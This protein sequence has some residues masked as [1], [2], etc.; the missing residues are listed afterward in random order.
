MKLDPTQLAAARPKQSTWLIANAGSGKTKVLV[1]RLLRLLLSGARPGGI[2]CLTFTKTAA[3]EM[4]KRVQDI[5]GR[6][7]VLDDESLDAE[8]LALG[9]EPTERK[10]QQARQLFLSLAEDPEGLNI[11]T[12]HGFCQSLISRFPLELGITPGTKLL[13]GEAGRTL[14][15]EL[16]Q[17]VLLDEGAEVSAARHQLMMG[18]QNNLLQ[19]NKFFDLAGKIE[20]HIDIENVDFDEFS[21]QAAKMFN[22]PDAEVCLEELEQILA[23]RIDFAQVRDVVA[24]L[25]ELNSDKK[26]DVEFLAT[27]E[28]CLEAGSDRL[29]K[30]TTAFLTKTRTIRAKPLTQKPMKDAFIADRIMYWKECILEHYQQVSA[31]KSLEVTVAVLRLVQDFIQRY[32][33]YKTA[34]ALLD[35]GDQI[36][37][38]KDLLNSSGGLEWV[39]YKLDCSIDHV[40]LDEAQDTSHD[41][42]QILNALCADFFAGD[43]GRVQTLFVVGDPKQSIYRFQGA[44]SEGFFRERDHR[45]QAGNLSEQILTQSYRSTQ[46][47]LDVVDSTFARYRHADFS[48]EDVTFADCQHL[49]AR[50]GFAG[51]VVLA[52]PLEFDQSS[53]AAR[54]WLAQHL[55]ETIH[56]W[57]GKR[58]IAALGRTVRAE[59]ILLLF[60]DRTGIFSEL[61]HHLRRLGVPVVSG[62][63][64]RFLEP[65]AV[66]DC[67]ALMRYLLRPNDDYQ[68][69]CVLK[70]AFI[71]FSEDD[72]MNLALNRGD[73]QSL[74]DALMQQET[75]AAAWLADLRRHAD[76]TSINSLLG[77]V[78]HRPCPRGRSGLQAMK[79]RF[80]QG[81]ERT[82]ARLEQL[83]IDFEDTE[84]T[85]LS[86]FVDHVLFRQSAEV[87]RAEGA[88]VVRLSTIHSAKGQQA[89]IVIVPEVWLTAKAPTIKLYSVQGLPMLDGAEKIEHPELSKARGQLL[90]AD[91]AEHWRLLYV[92]MT[93]AAFELHLYTAKKP[94]K[95]QAETPWYPLIEAGMN[96]QNAEI[97][98]DSE[99][100]PIFE[101]EG[102]GFS[103]MK[104]ARR[105][106]SAQSLPFIDDAGQTE[107]Q[108]YDIPAWLTTPVSAAKP[109][110]TPNFAPKSTPVGEDARLR[111]I[112]LHGLMQ[113]LCGAEQPLE[114][115]Q[116]ITPQGFSED[117]IA[118]M[119]EVLRRGLGNAEMAEILKNAQSE[120]E[121]VTKDGENR[122]LDCVEITPERITIVDFKSDQNPRETLP[123]GYAEQLQNYRVIMAEMFPERN[124]RTGVFWLEKACFS[125][126]D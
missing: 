119:R 63:S 99:A 117:E 79:G 85:G 105:Y 108:S 36:A 109:P 102:I 113:R 106:Y 4:L 112:A 30:F 19:P 41:Q 78:L 5:L 2:L 74:H 57:I 33:G 52:P 76:F 122:R 72:L 22:L 107:V 97:F 100:F 20:K 114:K 98:E 71:G 23:G 83:A 62:E 60:R 15:E 1:D 25:G 37:L 118:E 65:L 86:G 43:K 17:A 42:W 18:E 59:D 75:R 12:L 120:L 70:S 101:G 91:R 32:R 95:S 94:P 124:I 61:A 38:V 69:A 46:C 24:Y 92:A 29:W 21:A 82:L 126:Q 10:R 49:S 13:D 115:L 35:Y 51:Q 121:V 39:R 56:G 14:Q 44:D 103:T 80:G 125:W 88:G 116:K 31:L 111:G 28:G 3:N 34:H 55:A 77:A 87:D 9:E 96:D 68:L 110:F 53:S 45:V 50:A 104:P 90:A 11:R 73:K 8:I 93:R 26:T 89:P 40:F 6:W 81:V 84:T 54:R 67:V 16:R 123:K 27:L 66:R 47:L 58:Y 48:T 64:S 7:L